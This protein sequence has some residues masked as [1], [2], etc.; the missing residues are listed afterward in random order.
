MQNLPYNSKV[1]SSHPL[2]KFE[3]F[4]AAKQAP[5]PYGTP[6]PSYSDAILDAPPDYSTSESLAHA[7]PLP[8]HI[9]YPTYTAHHLDRPPVY[10]EPLKP[11]ML[12]KVDL[13]DSSNF[14]SHAGKKDKKN[15]KAAD[16]AKWA[17]DDSG[18]EGNKN[19][20]DAEENA[21]GAGGG[22]GGGS[23]NGDGGAGG[24]GGDDWN[25]GNSKKKKKGKK[26]K[27]G[28]D[29]E[30]E[31]KKNEE[32]EE[33]D[34]KKNEEQEEEDR[35]KSEADA[36]A[37]TGGNQL[38]WAEDGEVNGDDDWGGFTTTKLKKSKKGKVCHCVRTTIRLINNCEA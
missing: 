33:E 29:E 37:E 22:A 4:E 34:R 35:K 13:D 16:K 24:D 30:E 27:A 14:Q 5:S 9:R 18:D 10:L 23:N 25:T 31:R 1:L 6:P 17:G 12:P 38:A 15:K 2:S 11:M 21:G 36:A 32:Q 3:L 19:E 7:K 26:G 20:G 28:V 8:H